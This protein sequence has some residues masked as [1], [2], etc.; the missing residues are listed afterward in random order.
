MRIFRSPNSQYKQ[1]SSNII[2]KRTGRINENRKDSGL[3]NLVKSNQLYRT[4]N[5]GGK[6]VS[7]VKNS[8]RVHG[9]QYDEETPRINSFYA[10]K[11]QRSR[12]AATNYG[13]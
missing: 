4:Q 13:Q 7:K 2:D 11:Q 5:V 9:S 1:Y 8:S 12:N 6:K 3:S 10:P